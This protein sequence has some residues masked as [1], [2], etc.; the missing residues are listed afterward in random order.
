MDLRT[1][2]VRATLR[3]EQR[4]AKAYEMDHE[5]ARP[6]R[7]EFSRELARTEKLVQEAVQEVA[8]AGG[9]ANKWN[10]GAA[11]WNLVKTRLK[12]YQ[13]Y[14]E[15][16]KVLLIRQHIIQVQSRIAALPHPSEEAAI[17]AESPLEILVH[18]QA[19]IALGLAGPID[20]ALLPAGLAI[21]SSPTAQREIRKE[22]VA[23]TPDNDELGF[24][25]GFDV[26]AG[27]KVEPS[28]SSLPLS[29]PMDLMGEFASLPGIDDIPML[30]E[31]LANET[32]ISAAQPHDV[33]LD[34]SACN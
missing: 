19:S 3:Y 9:T 2:T 17:P 21:T 7:N 18:G 24:R 23:V 12:F 13:D 22:R 27:Q 30:L 5:L 34:M 33:S 11:A 10:W 16:A 4:K 6:L 15:E 32:F 20:R 29:T 28:F 1:R 14:K 31:M 25:L 26:N 8:L